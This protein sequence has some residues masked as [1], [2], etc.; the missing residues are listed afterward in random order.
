[1]GHDPANA[2]V[3]HVVTAHDVDEA[4]ACPPDERNAEAKHLA[5]GDQ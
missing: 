2:G 4:T 5:R 3:A 1:M